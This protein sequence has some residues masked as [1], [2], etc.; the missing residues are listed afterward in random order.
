[1]LKRQFQRKQ[2]IPALCIDEP[3]YS[4]NWYQ[5]KSMAISKMNKFPD[6]GNGTIHNQLT[7]FPSL[8][9]FLTF[10]ILSIFLVKR[11]RFN[12][13]TCRISS[14][15]WRNK[16]YSCFKWNSGSKPLNTRGC[17]RR[18]AHWQPCWMFSS[19]VFHLL[20][21]PWQE[22]TWHYPGT[23]PFWRPNITWIT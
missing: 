21:N 14:S 16:P 20:R 7:V 22:P 19:P 18:F 4:H 12:S 6:Q 1:M 13:V 9:S 17:V 2:P 15:R 5:E 10:L 8:I 23:R 3:R 11:I